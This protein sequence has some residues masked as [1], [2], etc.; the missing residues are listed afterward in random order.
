MQNTL[1]VAIVALLGLS[2]LPTAGQKPLSAQRGQVVL[3]KNC[4]SCHGDAKL[5]GLDLRQPLTRAKRD[6]LY[7]VVSGLEKLQMPPGKR[8]SAEEISSVK[9]WVAAPTPLVAT[10]THWAFLPVQARL[11]P[12]VEQ[13]GLDAFLLAKLKDK[14]LGFSKEADKRTLIRRVSFDLSGLPPT[15]G[16]TAAFLTD[17]KPGAY[18][19]VVERLLASPAY[20]ERQARRW[21]DLARYADSEGFKGDEMRPTAWRYRDYVVR[22]FNSDK[23]YD[24]FVKEQL[25]G[26]ELWPGDPEAL[27]ATGFSRHFPDESNARNIPL[28]RQEILNDITDV[29]GSV[30]L[31]LTVGCARCHDHKYDPV[32]QKDYYRL[33]AFFAAV[34]PRTDLVPLPASE[35]VAREQALTAWEEKTRETR[36]AL[37]TLEKPVRERLAKGKLEKFPEDLKEA[38]T[39]PPEKRTS[40]QWV[41][42]HQVNPQ[43]EPTEGEVTGAMEKSKPEV[44]TPWAELTQVLKKDLKPAALPTALGITD[45]GPDAPKTFLLT[46]GLYDQPG[47]EVTPGFLQALGGGDARFTASPTSTGRRAALANWITSPRNTLTARVMVNRLWQQHFGRGLVGTGNDFGVAGERPTHPEL[48]DWL[49]ERFIHD[50]GWSLKKLHQRIVLSMAYRQSA[51]QNPKA[52]KLDPE[53][54]LLWRFR[55]QR[56]EGESIRDALLAVSGQ[57]NS[58][59]GGPGV[60]AELPAGLTTTGYWK[61]TTELT[62]R[63]RRSLYLFVKRNL[64]YPLFE[65]FDFPDTHEPCAR[66]SQT[67]SPLQALLLLNDTTALR[68]AKAFAEQVEKEAGADPV[69]QITQ[70]WERAYNRPP[71]P[72]EITRA[73]A[74]LKQSNLTELCHALFNTNE[75]LYV[76]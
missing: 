41:L 31:G 65:A 70:A 28:R 73:V 17:T 23:P 53:N 52:T 45:V 38:V 46:G 61:E 13:S 35:R 64:R 49:T 14:G 71:Q 18:E 39:T 26:D 37:E 25:A 21:L 32:P 10:A 50:D 5:G 1:T 30:F 66:R 22:S 56:L 48:L 33:Q 34:R 68:L 15:L 42:V 6:R 62:E 43:I 75:F 57:L 67:T 36:T 16:E 60:M 58:K 24:R 12:P 76:E 72:D 40:R 7:R 55:R 63:N 74:F 4:L 2:A 11:E 27:L 59:Q 9:S 54:T 8:L 47:P 69:T 44:K 51:T 29:T 3:Q 19:R 20:G